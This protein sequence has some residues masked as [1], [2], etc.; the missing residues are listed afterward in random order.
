[1]IYFQNKL[2]YDLNKNK[3]QKHLNKEKEKPNI[4]FVA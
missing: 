1:M 2:F 4:I 3:K